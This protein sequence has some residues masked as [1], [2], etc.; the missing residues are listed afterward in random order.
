MFKNGSG[1][2]IVQIKDAMVVLRAQTT[3]HNPIQMSLNVSATLVGQGATPS[4][5]MK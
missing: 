5:C 2:I 3:Q 1:I 4:I